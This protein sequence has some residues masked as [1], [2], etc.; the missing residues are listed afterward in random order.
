MRPG[1]VLYVVLAS[2]ISGGGLLATGGLDS[3]SAETWQSAAIAWALL[4][5]CDGVGN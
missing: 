4:A 3:I 5:L 2:A 1:L